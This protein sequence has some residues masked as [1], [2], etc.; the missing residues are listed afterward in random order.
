MSDGSNTGYI[1]G[2]AGTIIGTLATAVAGLFKLVESKNSAAIEDLRMR[3]TES[4]AHHEEC[5]KDR[6]ELRVQ[7]AEMK[8]QIETNMARPS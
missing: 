1:V 7:I 4:D 5:R 3:V 6:E 8:V 2:A